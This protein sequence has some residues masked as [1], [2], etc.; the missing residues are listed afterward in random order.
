MSEDYYKIET[1]LGTEVASSQE[2]NVAWYED[3]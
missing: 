1:I 2:H 3:I